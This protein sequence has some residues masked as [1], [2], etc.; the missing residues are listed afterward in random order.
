MAVQCL[1]PYARHRNYREDIKRL[2]LASGPERSGLI[3]DVSPWVRYAAFRLV[4]FQLMGNP[5]AIDEFHDAIAMAME[6]EF[7]EVRSEVAERVIDAIAT[8]RSPRY[9]D[10]LDKII[11]EGSTEERSALAFRL[12]SHIDSGHDD[13]F[14]FFKPTFAVLLSAPERDV[15]AQIAYSLE[16]LAEWCRLLTDIEAKYYEGP[17]TS[18]I[19]YSIRKAFD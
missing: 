5:D 13:I 19:G 2:L 1:I 17:F 9:V 11:A 14:D 18:T 8:T 10:L 6:D 15:R 7:V 4:F 16:D 3:S 12:R